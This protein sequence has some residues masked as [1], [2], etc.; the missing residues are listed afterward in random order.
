MA[1]APYSA[2]FFRE[3]INILSKRYGAGERLEDHF[4][5]K[6]QRFPPVRRLDFETTVELNALLDEIY[7]N[8]KARYPYDY[9]Q[10]LVG[11]HWLASHIRGKLPKA[12]QL[13]FYGEITRDGRE[14]NILTLRE[15]IR[16]RYELLSRCDPYE[17]DEKPG[18]SGEIRSYPV[19]AH[20]GYGP[21]DRGY[22]EYP[23]SYPG[24]YTSPYQGQEVVDTRPVG[25]HPPPA[26]THSRPA[27]GE[28]R[29]YADER[30]Y[31][32]AVPATNRQKGATG[33]SGGPPQQGFKPRTFDPDRK[34][35]KCPACGED[36]H[37]LANCE[38]FSLL[39]LRERFILVRQS[40]CC[41]HCLG[42]GHGIRDCPNQPNKV[43]GVEGCQDKHH[44]LVHRRKEIMAFLCSIE[45]YMQDVESEEDPSNEWQ[46]GYIS[47][48]AFKLDQSNNSGQAPVIP[49][50][51]E[52][53]NIAI[54][55]V[56]CDIVGVN[57]RRRVVVVLDSGA[58]NTNIDQDLARKLGLRV[59]RAGVDRE[60]HQVTGCASIR[61]DFVEFA[62]C[63]CDSRNGPYFEIGG[64]TVKNLVSGT[65]V[66]DW[67]KAAE[68][69]PHLKAGEPLKPGSEDQV[70][71]LLGTDFA[72]LM[73]P[74]KVL[75]GRGFLDPTGELT[76]L[77]WAFKGRTGQFCY[78][79]TVDAA[80]FNRYQSLLNWRRTVKYDFDSAIQERLEVGIKVGMLD[81]MRR[82]IPATP[83]ADVS[84]ETVYLA[85]Q[86]RYP[87]VDPINRSALRQEFARELLEEYKPREAETERAFCGQL[88]HMD[89]SS[90][91]EP[92]R[93]S[94]Y[95]D[96]T[97]VDRK[98]L[99]PDP[100][101]VETEIPGQNEEPEED[102]LTKALIFSLNEGK[103]DGGVEDPYP[104]ETDEEAR[105]R[106][107]NEQLDR[108]LRVHWEMEAV[109]MAEKRARSTL[110]S[111]Q[112]QEQWTPAQKELDD[113]MG[114]RYL[115][116]QKRFELTIPWKAGDK[117]N[118]KC[119]RF[120][121]KQRQDAVLYKLT[122][123]RREK[124]IKIFE[125]YLA[126]GYVR[127]LEPHEVVD[128]DSRY[129][130][131]FCVVD[132]TKDTTPVRVVWDCKAVYHGKSLNSEI[133]DTPNR[134]QNI[135]YVSMRMR[136]YRYTLTSDV[137]EMFL[138]IKLA[139]KDRRY[140]RFHLDGVDY[141]WT[142]ILFGN[143]ASPN[144][145][146]KV[147]A[148]VCEMFGA[149]YPEAVESLTKSLYMDDVS[150][151]RPT[152]EQVLTLAQQL[153]ALLGHCSMPI[154][155]FYSNSP[156]VVASLD[157]KLLAKQISIGE[158]LTEFEPSKILGMCYNAGP[159]ADYLSFAGKFRNVRE[160]TNKSQTTKVEPGH[161]TKR[162]VARAA[163]SIYD[164]HGLIAPFTVRS[165]TI[166]QE[167]WKKKE[168]DWDSQLPKELCSRWEGWMEQAFVIPDIQ[169][170]RW[171]HFEPKSSFQIHAFCDASEE[172]LCT[173][174]YLRVKTRKEVF[175]T[176]LAGKAR[177]SPLKAESISRLELAACVMGVRLVG[178]VQEVYQAAADQV[179]FW[180][181][182]MVC[183]HWI[184]VPAKAFKAFAAHRV[185]EIQNFTEPRQWSHV[186]TKEN[187]A[188]L[189]TRP[190]TALELK[191]NPLWWQGPEFL[192]L[193]PTE[194]PKRKIIPIAEDPELK[195]T[196][197]KF[198]P[199][200]VLGKR[201]PERKLEPRRGW[202]IVDPAHNSTGRLYDAMNKM[203]PVLAYVIRFARG[204]RRG[205]RLETLKLDPGEIEEAKGTLVRIAQERFF[206]EEI[207]IL[208]E[209]RWRNEP[210]DISTDERAR[211]SRILRLSPFLDQDDLLRCRSRLN[212]QEIYGYDKTYPIILDKDSSLARMLVERA[213]QEIGHPVGHNAAKARVSSKY[214]ILGLGTL[215]KSLKWKCVYCQIRS[216]RPAVQQ[217][218][219]L[220][221][222]RLGPKLRAFAD[223][224][225]D[226][227]GPFEIKMGRGKPRRKV[228]ILLITCLAT[229]A[230]HLEATG[231]METT[232][233]INA[234][235]RMA[236]VRGVPETMVTDNQTS[237]AKADKDLR[238]WL[239]SLDFHQIRQATRNFR[240]SRGIEWTFNPPHAPHFGGI[241]EIMIKAA[242]RALYDTIR[243]EDLTEEEF[244]TVVSKVAWM[245]NQRPIQRVGDTNDFETLCP[246]HFLGGSP[247]E[248][249]FPPDLPETRMD[250]PQRL[251]QQLE[252]QRHFWARFQQEI[253]PELAPRTKW[254]SRIADFKDG[255]LAVEV[256]DKSRRGEW[257][258][259]RIVR[260][261][262]SVDGAVRKVEIMDHERRTF[263]RPIHGLIPIRM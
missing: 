204:A 39:P 205:L 244:R 151:S 12:E 64:F 158:N 224:G 113:R 240:G 10:R 86:D 106:V 105:L 21:S 195:Q 235:S 8:T 173:A 156:L 75:R 24:S 216:S 130:P 116:D 196:I 190:I 54:K 155:K 100:G 126:K 259:V 61:S 70:A 218:A 252:I 111:E 93:E 72:N 31:E 11:W 197:F 133:A 85:I 141:E 36:T 92:L 83:G 114:I 167:I 210:Q 241:Y 161:W 140:H 112:T 124:V 14:E 43:C 171:A 193:P 245:L 48:Q 77:G 128:L 219:A 51:M 67:Q 65:P 166:L 134:L 135:F 246:A 138:R 169:I 19:R 198:G 98:A 25:Y 149:D 47:Q 227:A 132:E 229:R 44:P 257:R 110:N 226:Y 162:C 66:T 90:K 236:D 49:L 139:E 194:W 68:V 122:P 175:V 200:Q 242:K 231:G 73:T 238:A 45:E 183:L 223:C 78:R 103:T 23:Q 137:S 121:V 125:D 34:R 123:E 52:L 107:D 148:A 143:V 33:G 144:G 88:Y 233:V 168:L 212:K 153:I 102:H 55:T 5:L 17:W 53:E 104:T 63:P 179:F 251:K 249:A 263:V 178:A 96:P 177:V 28:F 188:D 163:A 57:F 160:W 56:T 170:P 46:V 4:S 29:S 119:N 76:D 202:S 30:N 97:R 101:D 262:P 129:L 211:K 109:G 127:P 87:D 180:T 38:K 225:M 81:D 182:S 237:F 142:S 186:P 18:R 84:S 206:P 95:A 147:M 62:L 221:S 181:D 79:D 89:G 214:A 16:Y 199:K 152:E 191:N 185:G 20:P 255:D 230:V 217:Q 2:G 1:S 208:R 256:D 159:E 189:G 209:Q 201:L 203:L 94:H 247:D 115:P 59:I 32:A 215:I 69:Y 91:S 15:Y 232:H 74:Y 150:D 172:A 145:S 222:G 40:R 157:S 131:F 154:H 239:E 261:I 136:L 258:K 7:Y 250:L 164:P 37:W 174:V 220:P 27:E 234:L 165:K 187:P 260:T 118:F 9:E 176:L 207:K 35:G 3:A 22:E 228:W 60:M 253:V 50:P 184:N 243:R 58:N 213:H 41:Y 13:N 80:T 108:L 117:P 71:I 99:E 192:K 26:L 254:L 6:V 120:A 248:A 82:G 146:Q 42:W